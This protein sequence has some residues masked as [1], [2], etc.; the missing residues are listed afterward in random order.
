MRMPA[1]HQTVE[2][3]LIQRLLPSRKVNGGIHVRTAMLRH[4]QA[5]RSIVVSAGS[6]SCLLDNE[7]EILF[8]RPRNGV[9]SE[10]MREIDE[11]R[12]LPEK[13]IRLSLTG[14]A[15]GTPQY[16]QRHESACQ[17]STRDAP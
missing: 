15:S 3:D 1:P 8:R 5:I 13:C 6:L 14:Q 16:C 12:L 9:G 4:L 7:S 10:R 2:G 11:T 17:V